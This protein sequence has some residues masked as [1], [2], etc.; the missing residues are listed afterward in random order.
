MSREGEEPTERILPRRVRS[1]DT[2]AVVAP[3][4]AEVYWPEHRGSRGQAYLEHLGLRVKVMAHAGPQM[5]GKT[6]SA[7]DRAADINEAFADP[8]VAVVLCSIGGNESID[9]VPHLDYKLI[10]ANPKVFQGLS[11]ATV[12][13]WAIRKHSGLVTFHGPALLPELGE[14]PDVLG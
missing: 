4:S 12:L 14:Y 6:V 7:V 10:S 2:V 13:H 11:D 3:C 9:V 1:G 8:D 5:A